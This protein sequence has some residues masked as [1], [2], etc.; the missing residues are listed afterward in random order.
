M[1]IRSSFKDYYDGVLG[2][3]PDGPWWDRQPQ[4]WVPAA[5]RGTIPRAT[6]SFLLRQVEEAPP[7]LGRKARGWG[8]DFRKLAPGQAPAQIVTAEAL[9]PFASTLQ[10]MPLLQNL[11]LTRALLL[12]AGRIHPFV[13]VPWGSHWDF[14]WCFAAES[15]EAFAA[16]LNRIYPEEPGSSAARTRQDA[17]AALAAAE[18][19]ASKRKGRV[20]PGYRP[21]APTMWAHYRTSLAAL[22]NPLELHR[23]WASPLLLLLIGPEGLTLE[24]NPCLRDFQVMRFLDA[25]QVYQQ[26]DLYLGN[27][28]VVQHDP[29]AKQ[30]DIENLESHGFDRK[31]SFRHPTRL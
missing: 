31:T 12:L 5:A 16:N 9:R 29:P 14:G 30:T 3:D 26:L 13:L 11:G 24:V 25:V 22:P 4:T 28:L 2:H 20:F 15:P 10:D 17:Q 6:Q 19:E 27:D 18:E 1:R 23:A 8:A 7:L 21:Y